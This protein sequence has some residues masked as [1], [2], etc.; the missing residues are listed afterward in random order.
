MKGGINEGRRDGRD[1]GDTECLGEP[2]E[3]IS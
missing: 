1:G 3:V 2:E